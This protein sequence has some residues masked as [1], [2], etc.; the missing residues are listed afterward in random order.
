MTDHLSPSIRLLIVDDH[1]VVRTGLAGML[2]GES[3]FVVVGEAPDGVQALE[4]ITHH[5]PD[6]V[7]L[8]LRM[9]RLDGVGV[10]EAL[11]RTNGTPRVLVLT[12]YDADGDILRAID[13]GADGYLL[14]D[15]PRDQLFAAIRATMR[16]ESWL[17]PTVATRL[18]TRLRAPTGETLSQREVE[19]LSLASRG[20]SN[21]EIAAD[22]VISQATVKSHLIRIYRKLNVAD[23]TAAVTVALERGLIHLG[24]DQRPS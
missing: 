8:D 16:N 14:K 20:A 19:V 5:R 11:D 2:A 12:T 7:L 23:R 21:K 24:G 10:L 4:A 13:A 18:M 1:P 3:D 9:P 6:V 22:L 17:A 15:A